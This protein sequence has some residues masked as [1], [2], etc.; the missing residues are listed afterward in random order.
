MAQGQFTKQE[1]DATLTAVDEMFKA[2]SRPKQGEYLGHLNDICL[3]IGA[4]KK[5]APNKALECNHTN[6]VAVE[7]RGVVCVDCGAHL[8]GD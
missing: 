5:A 7:G 6:T 3:F 8:T 1:A 4:A 2:L